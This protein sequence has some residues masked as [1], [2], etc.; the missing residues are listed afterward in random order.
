M[1]N[2]N[3]CP[4]GLIQGHIEAAK[5]IGER[6]ADLSVS[7]VHADAGTRASAEMHEI[8]I[9]AL[10]LGLR[11]PVLAALSIQPSFGPELVRAWEDLGLVVDQVD[12]HADWRPGWDDPVPELERC[13]GRYSLQPRGDAARHSIALCD[14]GVQV[15]KLF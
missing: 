2:I 6:E 8:P 3:V 7:E 11:I 13:I 14:D 15:R 1:L 5:E 12:G 4:R 10:V 9:P